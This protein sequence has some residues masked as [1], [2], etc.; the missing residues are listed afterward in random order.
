VDARV[1]GPAYYRAEAEHARRL[2]K[3]VYN[4]RLEKML[5]RIAEDCDRE[6]AK[7]EAAKAETTLSRGHFLFDDPD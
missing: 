7:V 3:V 2:A 6:A 4:P 5:L 1:K